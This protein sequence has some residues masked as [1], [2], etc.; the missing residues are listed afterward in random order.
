MADL[1]LAKKKEWAKLLY[2]KE[3]LTQAEIAGRVGVTRVTVNKWINSGKWEMLKVSI[4]ITREEQLKNMYRQL[5]ELNAAILNRAEGERYPN[6]AESDTIGKLSK[7]IRQMETE[8]GLSEITSVLGGLVQ[9]L[10][11]HEPQLL[12]ETIAP[13]LDAYVKSKLV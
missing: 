11:T 5:A 12:R 6:A 13:L 4:T 7:A 1:T 3:N 9:Y 10:R 8:V 2:T